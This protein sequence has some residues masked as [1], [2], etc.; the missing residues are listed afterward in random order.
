MHTR[1]NRLL[2]GLF[3]LG[4]VILMAG[5]VQEVRLKYAQAMRDAV[6]PPASPQASSPP[7]PVVS[8]PPPAPGLPEDLAA[9]L[10]AS[11]VSKPKPKPKSQPKKIIP[12]QI[13]I[14]KLDK[15]LPGVPLPPAPKPPVAAPAPPQ[16]GDFDPKVLKKEMPKP[17]QAP[18]DVELPPVVVEKDQ[19]I[20]SQSGITMP[21]QAVFRNAQDWKAFWDKAIAPYT[22]SLK[23]APEI[24]FSKEMVVSVFMG[25]EPLAGYQIRILSA[26]T[27]TDGAEKVLT[28][29]YRNLDRFLGIFAPHFEVQPFHLLKMPAFTGKIQFVESK[30]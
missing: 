8:A 24:N 17:V 26:S 15:P 5:L 16:K 2:Q 6:P 30:K 4:L 20:G 9:A 14:P 23:V 18:S 3:V 21:M 28:I 7:A 10:T 19:W 1:M 27:E 12:A 13:K 29:H 22:P 11:P 25:Q